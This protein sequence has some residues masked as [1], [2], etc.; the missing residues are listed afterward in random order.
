MR[1]IGDNNWLVAG[2]TTNNHRVRTEIDRAVNNQV[3]PVLLT[4]ITD[5]G[6]IGEIVKPGKQEGR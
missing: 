6:F 5:D 1:K 2:L 4:E 3:L